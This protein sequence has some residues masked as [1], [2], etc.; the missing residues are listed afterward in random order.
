MRVR[1]PVLLAALLAALAAASPAAAREWLAGDGHVHTCFSHD[2]YCPQYDP[3]EDAETFYS[4]FGTVQQRFTE[5]AAKGLHFLVVSDHDDIRAWSDPAFGTQGVVGVRAYEWSLDGGHAQMLGAARNYGD[6]DAAATADALNA[7]GGLFQANH[8]SYRADAVVSTCEDVA[9]PE[10]PLHWKLGFDVRPDAIE[11]WNATALI[12]PGELFWECWLQRGIRMPVTAGSD[13]HGATQPNLGMPTTWVLA[14]DRTQAAILDAI[15]LG[16][17]TLSRLPPGQGGARLLLEADGDRDGTYEAT[18]GDTVK[19]GSPMRVRADGLTAPALIRVRA[20]GRTVV[21][22]EPLQ[23][24]G[25]VR[26]AAPAQPTWVRAVAYQQQWTAVAD[27]FC[28]PP[29]SAES[30]VDLC[31]NDLA[32][33]GMTSPLYLELPVETEPAKPGRNPRPPR[34]E[35]PPRE[36]GA[37]ASS[38]DD[39]PDDDPPLAPALQSLNGAPLPVVPAQDAAARR[40]GAQRRRAG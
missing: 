10:T 38:H 13:S 19:P 7:D 25:E 3:P 9:G 29:G 6:G 15:R 8:P 30:P 1:V 22:D 37:A 27:P 40:T 12:P 33:T 5:A 36:G 21:E 35:R 18:V 17:T 20:A 16:R 24:G 28:R 14:E 2:A 11:V 34:P 31:T 32:I 4:S 26:F 23:P 39:E